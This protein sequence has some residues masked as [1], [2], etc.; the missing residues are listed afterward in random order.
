MKIER[1][2]AE[3]LKLAKQLDPNFKE[4]WMPYLML[5]LLKDGV[6]GKRKKRIKK[7][8]N[9]RLQTETQQGRLPANF[10]CSR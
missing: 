10:T 6:L 9:S 2:E 4:E 5:D 3:L 8:T 7:M 1:L